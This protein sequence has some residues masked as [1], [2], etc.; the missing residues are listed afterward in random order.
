MIRVR[1][2]TSQLNIFHTRNELVE[3]DEAVNGFIASHGIRKVFSV[4]D[5]VTTGV[6]GEA[7][8]IIRV[9]TYE[10]PGEGSREKILGKMEKKLNVWGEEIETLRGKADELSAGARTKWKKQVEDLR[11][12]QE[13]T[14]KKL[15]EM[16]KSGGETWE[17]LRAGTEVAL[18]DLK[19]AVQ[20]AVRKRKE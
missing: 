8:G 6:K 13:S 18:E 4:S 3:L 11:A 10:E 17:D 1:T 7:I 16:K 14:R 15:L 19:K 9:V 12:M 5:A 2:F 20:K